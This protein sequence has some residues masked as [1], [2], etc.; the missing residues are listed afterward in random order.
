M[1][2]KKQTEKFDVSHIEVYDDVSTKRWSRK[3]VERE[4]EAIEREVK[5]TLKTTRKEVASAR[6]VQRQLRALISEKA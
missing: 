3:R 6:R 1:T 4:I 2:K 5:S